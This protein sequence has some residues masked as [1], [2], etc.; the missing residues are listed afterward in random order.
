M[1]GKRKQRSL[2]VETGHETIRIGPHFEVSFQRTLRIPDDGNDYPLPPGLGR[3]PVRRVE[4]YL[5]T[6][7]A[8][9]RKHGGVFIPL[10]VRD[11]LWL[12]F[13][14]PGHRAC[15]V[16]VGAGRI[17][18]VSGEEWSP[19]LTGD[20][21]D[22][23]YLV[24]PDQPWLDGFNS[25]NGFI[26][27]FV[28]TPLGLGYTVEEQITGAAEFGGIQLRV[29]E[30]KPGCFP[31][32]APAPPPGSHLLNDEMAVC[33]L[34]DVDSSMGLG[35]GGRM[36]QKIYPDPHGVETWDPSRSGE[37]HIHL[38]DPATYEQVTGEPAPPTPVNADLYTS[39]GYPWFELEDDHLGDVPR[40]DELARVRSVKEVDVAK[41]TLGADEGS[42]DVPEKQV[43]GLAATKG[44]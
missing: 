22:P 13:S 43:V 31:D 28:A 16:K 36:V 1:S 32:E 14:V 30:P 15:A 21:E 20:S 29:F 10:H 12:S 11:A 27:Q 41:G 4:D 2:E 9:W 44:V 7:P 5:E 34:S 17:N 25:G 23:D 8:L 3:L 19:E 39:Y 33:C 42:I 35:A 38:A 18:A 37:V 40:S 6:A 24:C 26:R